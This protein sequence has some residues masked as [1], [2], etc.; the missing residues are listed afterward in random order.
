MSEPIDLNA[1]RPTSLNGRRARR[2]AEAMA[3][4][5]RDGTALDASLVA[6][7]RR[8]GRDRTE[9]IEQLRNALHAIRAAADGCARAFDALAEME[10]TKR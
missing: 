7:E 5:V 6:L 10:E 3:A 1:R 9:P 8:D 2:M 4:L